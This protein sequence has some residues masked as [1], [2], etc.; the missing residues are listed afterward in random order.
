M[1]SQNNKSLSE[2]INAELQ[3]KLKEQ[4]GLQ[5]RAAE[6]KLLSSS[7]QK[8]RGRRDHEQML[9]SEEEI[10][11]NEKELVEL[12]GKIEVLEQAIQL[13]THED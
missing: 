4:Q 1:A 5:R 11:Q 8:S 2:D 9:S 10:K 12:R 13:L 6:L 3:A 7:A